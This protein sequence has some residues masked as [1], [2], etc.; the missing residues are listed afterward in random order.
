MSSDVKCRQIA[1]GFVTKFHVSQLILYTGADDE[2]AFQLACRD[3]DQHKVRGIRAYRGEPVTGRKYCTFLVEFSDGE[4]CWI[5]YGPDLCRTEVFGEYCAK[6]PELRIL[7]MPILRAVEMLKTERVLSIPQSF[8]TRTW[9]LDLRIF[10]FTWY[11]S[12]QLPESDTMTYVIEATFHKYTN[13][14]KTR[15]EMFV[16]LFKE[17]LRNLDFYWF[18]VNAYR[19]LEHCT[20]ESIV[21]VDD[22]L[23]TQYPYILDASIIP[24]RSPSEEFPPLQAGTMANRLGKYSNRVSKQE[25]TKSNIAIPRSQ[26]RVK[27]D[28][29]TSSDNLELTSEVQTEIVAPAREIRRSSRFQ[30]NT[31]S[32]EPKK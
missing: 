23:I 31:L 20:T 25:Q 18:R 21:M 9:F 29:N 3:D 19:R 27:I 24:A 22:A 11:D 13:T 1:T 7:L 12:L 6:T 5:Q 4:L 32:A 26:P 14:R 30:K 17:F 10:S 15:A 28:D 2:T 16:P 8:T